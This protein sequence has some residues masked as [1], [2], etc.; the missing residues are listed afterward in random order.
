[1]IKSLRAVGVALSLSVAG[2]CASTSGSGASTGA[3]GFEYQS[4]RDGQAES[5]G[6]QS[7]QGF[8]GQGVGGSG[9]G[10]SPE[11]V[12]RTIYFDY[13]SAEIRPSSRPVVEEH[14]RY[15]QQNP[16]VSVLLEGHTDERG[17]RE[18]NIALG[19]RRGSAVRDLMLTLGVPA[20]QINTV[21]YGEERPADAAGNDQAYALNRR[22][23]IA[24]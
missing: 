12:G 9:I 17:T 2:G 16:A 24:Y 19:D 15:L 23:E 6:Y 22:V 18:Y 14:V 4:T 8:N 10:P 21:S 11:T 20:Q 7:G 1:M 13:D 5:F 3:E